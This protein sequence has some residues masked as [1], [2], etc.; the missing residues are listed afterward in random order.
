LSR[1]APY[2]STFDRTLKQMLQQSN[3]QAVQN[4]V[5]GQ[6]GHS[7]AGTCACVWR[8]QNV[9]RNRHPEFPQTEKRSFMRTIEGIQNERSKDRWTKVADRTTY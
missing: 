4:A 5:I 9:V 7:V 2:L 8:V 6:R 3:F 1:D